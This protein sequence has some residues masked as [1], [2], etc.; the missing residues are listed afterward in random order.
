VFWDEVS[1]KSREEKENRKKIR[2]QKTVEKYKNRTK[3]TT[4]R[5]E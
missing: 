4:S 2:K 1:G 5:E 3:R